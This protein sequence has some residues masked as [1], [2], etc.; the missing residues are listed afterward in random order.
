MF[1]CAAVGLPAP[2]IL[3]SWSPLPDLPVTSCTLLE[4]V[5]EVEMMECSFQFQAML[6]LNQTMVHCMVSNIAGTLPSS[7]ASLLIAGRL[8]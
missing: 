1:T 3:W 8:S 4:P 7:S 6:D 2:T 5:G